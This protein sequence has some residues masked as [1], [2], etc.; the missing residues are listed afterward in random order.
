MPLW[1]R[2]AFWLF[3]LLV[4]VL[5]IAAILF[6]IDRSLKL[7]P[8]IA[9]DVFQQCRTLAEVEALLGGPPG[10][11]TTVPYTFDAPDSTAEKTKDIHNFIESFRR[12]GRHWISD[13]GCV[14][15]SLDPSGRIART[16]EV[17]VYLSREPNLLDKVKKRFRLSYIPE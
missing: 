13:D 1:K 11:Y 14:M 15:V 2:I 10:D 5:A 9:R 3:V 4:P 7:Y 16:G 6:S 17:R 12:D 8:G